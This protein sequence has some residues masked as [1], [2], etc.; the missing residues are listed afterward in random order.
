M[1]ILLI[2]TNRN[3][4]PLPVMPVGTCI[5]A[6]ASE[7]AGHTVHLL[8][9]M[10]T[11]DAT[12]AIHSAMAAFRPDIVGLSVRNIDN[13]D[14]LNPLFFLDDLQEIVTTIHARTSAPI[15]LGGAALGVMPEQILRLVPD[16]IA[17]VG[18]GEIIFPQLLERI[19]RNE[20]FK[21]LHGIACI[22]DDV[23]H[24]NRD[25]ASGFS[26]TC[27]APD[28]QRWLDTGAYR[29]H[30]ATAPIQTKTGCQFHCVYCS[31]PVI[32][33]SRYRFK[34]PES[35]AE[36]VMQLSAKGNRDIEFV[37][38]VFNAPLEHAMNVCASLGRIKHK[39]RLHC[40][41][42]NPL[43]FNDS[44]L[45]EMER[46]GF[47]SMGITL[48]SASDQVLQG[49]RKGFTSRD[50]HHAAEVVKRRRIPCAWIFMFGGPGE[51]RETVR[52]TL[53]FAETC[54]RPD[55]VVF[56]NT[57]IRIYPGTELELIA[58]KQGLLSCPAEEMLA[59]RFYISPDVDAGW[60]E[61][62]LKRAMAS[63]MNFIN[64]ATLELSFLPSIN[65][66]G[67]MLGLRP[68]LWRYTRIM[69]RVLR[70]AGMDV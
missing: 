65:R 51:T 14:M 6:H 20:S 70:L 64:I 53:R 49:L 34:N 32:E 43:Y 26:V 36:A 60:M 69:R 11:Q 33:G 54:V 46:A 61:Q 30:L 9:L 22:E 27:Q 37:D 2:S 38:S 68:P 50:V 25:A 62:E 45:S 39:A 21:D 55:D 47:A 48:E 13:V 23:F 63:R 16:C 67:F 35:I 59:P 57:G 40:L 12:R 41:E 4:L 44:L 56:F 10:F 31:Y 5:I 17:V 52:E 1:K 66:I 19:S 3:A 7:R 29:S 28:Y 15:I 24:L 18:D 58:R 8:D 42:L